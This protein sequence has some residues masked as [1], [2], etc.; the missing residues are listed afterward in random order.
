MPDKAS[1]SIS[2]KVLGGMKKRE[3]KHEE[4]SEIPPYFFL[5]PYLYFPFNFYYAL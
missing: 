2:D 4:K 3:E 5:K 1:V